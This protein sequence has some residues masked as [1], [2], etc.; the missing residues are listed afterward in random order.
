MCLLLPLLLVAMLQVAKLD[1]EPG[2]LQARLKEFN[3]KREKDKVS[4]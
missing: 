2:R 1:A 4:V 3:Q